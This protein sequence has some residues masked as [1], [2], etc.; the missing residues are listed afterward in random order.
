VRAALDLGAVFC[1][2]YLDRGYVEDLPCFIPPR[3][4][5]NKRAT[6]AAASFHPV[7]LHVLR[8]FDHGQRRAFVPFLAA[9][10]LAAAFSF[11]AELS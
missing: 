5:M 7:N 9:G 10:L 11:S 1:H 8:V 4:L 2:L 3:F 6:A